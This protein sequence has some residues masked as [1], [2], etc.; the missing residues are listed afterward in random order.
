MHGVIAYALWIRRDLD[1]QP[2]AEEKRARGFDEMP[3]VRGMLMAHLDLGRD[4]SLAI[5]SVYGRWFPWLV[6]LDRAWAAA[7]VSAI[8]P[9]DP[10]LA[11]PRDVAWDTYVTF[12]PP[13]DNILPLLEEEYTRAAERVGTRAPAKRFGDD[14]NEALANHLTTLYARGK[15]RLDDPQAPI[16]S[17]FAHAP[18]DLRLHALALIGRALA[19]ESKPVPPLIL[20]RLTRL[21]AARVA[22]MRTAAKPH[23]DSREL[24]AIGSWFTSG[25]F[26]DTWVLAELEGV[27][28]RTGRVDPHHEVINRLAERSRAKPRAAAVCVRLMVQ[29][30]RDAWIV[31]GSSEQIREIAGRA[32]K[33]EDQETRAA[34]VHLVNV[35]V[36]Q[37]HPEFKELLSE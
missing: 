12:C 30:D 4:P 25:A 9:S 26:D 10:S 34:G 33:S 16:A 7:H 15:M 11:E 24:E 1:S 32:L 17:F 18:V 28:E 36:A 37:G 31:L 2:N 6:L 13:Y 19:R 8:F 22:A 14:P 20:E 23:E 5:R 29:G 21:W 27:L 35:L 3:E